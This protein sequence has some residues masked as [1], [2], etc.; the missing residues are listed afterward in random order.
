MPSAC[1]G[2]KSVEVEKSLFKPKASR[3]DSGGADLVLHQTAEEI[4]GAGEVRNITR[5]RH[6]LINQKAIDNT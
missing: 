5:L 2:H 4:R 1:G 6:I 3:S